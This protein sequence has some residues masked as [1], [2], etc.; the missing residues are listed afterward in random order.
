MQ[1]PWTVMEK[2]NCPK[3]YLNLGSA[4]ET[5]QRSLRLSTPIQDLHLSELQGEVCRMGT[6][7]LFWDIVEPFIYK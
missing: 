6:V 1:R 4:R 5:A 3:V 2:L 7:V